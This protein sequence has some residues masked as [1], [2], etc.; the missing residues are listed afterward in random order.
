MVKITYISASGEETILDA[1]VGDSVM[2]TAV[3]ASLPGVVGECGGA[4]ACATCRVYVDEAWRSRTGEAEDIEQGMLEFSNDATEGVRLSC[5]IKV[6]EEL[7]GLIVRTPE[8]Q[9]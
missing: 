3:R 1:R 7:E 4:C 6:T 2:E 5:Q 9:Y 8:S